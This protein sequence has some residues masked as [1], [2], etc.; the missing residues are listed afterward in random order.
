MEEQPQQAPRAKTPAEVLTGRL[1][2]QPREGNPDRRGKPT[3]TAR[4]LAH[5]EG[6]EGAVPLFATFHGRTRDIAL[7]LN[8][9][10]QITAQGYLHPSRD[11]EGK[12]LGTFSVVHLLNYTG[13]RVVDAGSS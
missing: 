7:S 8:E 3:A 10:D 1:D 13:K 6:V 2:N 9:G 5:K 4:L 11:P 12:R